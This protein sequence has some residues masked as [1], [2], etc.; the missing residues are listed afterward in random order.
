MTE[1]SSHKLGEVLRTAREAKGV[2]LLR[3]ERDTKI[4][5]RYLAAL[6]GGEYRDL[7]G[8][9]YTKGFLRNYGLYLSLDPE[10]LI[11][12]YRLESSTV[13][14]E[15]AS[16]APPPRPIAVRRSRGFV[17]TPG[18]VVAAILTVVVFSIGAYLA[19]QLIAFAGTPQLRVVDPPG[20][21]AAYDGDSYTFQGVTAPGARVTVTGPRENPV[22]TADAEGIFEV[23]VDLVPGSNIVRLVAFDDT[24]GRTSAEVERAITVLTALPSGSPVEPTP[25]ALTAPA[26][27]ATVVGPVP[28]AGTAAP[29]A[30]VN[31]A[32]TLTTAAPATFTIVDGAGRPVTVSTATPAAPAPLALVADGAG[33]FT[34]QLALAP[35]SWIIDV[36][37]EDGSA[38]TRTVVVDAPAGLA[39]SLAISGG[40]SYIELD[41]DG[42]AKTGVSGTIVA[43]GATVATTATRELRIRAGNAG[44]VVVTLNG[45]RIGPMGAAGNVIEWRITRR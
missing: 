30:T 17:L 9:V 42:R 25:V 12:L 45:V 13:S 40:A 24:T 2:D 21:V 22:V 5:V 27:N 44:A 29:G 3:V 23:V 6:E 11:D 32:A 1:A 26:D 14:A 35:G 41:E 18:V 36:A 38:I 37:T 33:T 4:R 20:P 15:R 10:Y 8:A 7:P 28:L 43:D 34:G 19:A 16:V 31:V 39:G